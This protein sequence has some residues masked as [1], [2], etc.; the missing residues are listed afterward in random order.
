[1]ASRSASNTSF[2]RSAS[3][4]KAAKARLSAYFKEDHKDA[5]FD[6][7]KKDGKNI[8][9][10]ILDNF[11]GF[12]VFGAEGYDTPIAGLFLAGAGSHPGGGISGVPGM[13]AARRVIGMR[14]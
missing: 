7:Y 11:Y 10:S 4:L 12:P 1:M 14:R 8:P 6:D 9:W 5:S 3:D 13:N 2:L